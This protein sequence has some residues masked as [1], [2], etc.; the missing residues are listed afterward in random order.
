MS[1]EVVESSRTTTVDGLVLVTVRFVEP[2][3]EHFA[4]ALGSPL[5]L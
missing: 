1:D 4:F 3:N 5:S 2:K